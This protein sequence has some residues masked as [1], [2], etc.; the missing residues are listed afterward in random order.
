MSKPHAVLLVTDNLRVGGV[1]KVVLQIARLLSDADVRVGILAAGGP[2][3]SKLPAGVDF[4]R[5]SDK[6]DVLRRIRSTAVEFNYRIVHSHQRGVSSAARV[7]L[8]GTGIPIVEHVH[9]V[10]IPNFFARRFSFHGHRLIACGA[11]IAE[12]LH[13]DFQRT[14]SRVR[15]VLNAVP[16]LRKGERI[17][18]PA[19]KQDASQAPIRLITVA[20]MS[21]QKDPMR[22]LAVMEALNQKRPGGWHLTWV[23]GGDLEESFAAAI[24]DRNLP[25]DWLGERDDVPELLAESD[26]LLLTSQW[27][28]LPLV[29]LE[30]MRAGI[31][32]I[33]PDVGSCS[34]AIVDSQTG[35]LYPSEASSQDIAAR[36]ESVRSSLSDFGAAGRSRFMNQFTED[37][38]LEEIFSVYQELSK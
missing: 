28:G 33:A 38:M 21:K 16:S 36:L 4:H 35:V 7:V 8:V 1:Q 22:A 30:A 11:Q 2:L 19:Y 37:R 13:H 6:F 17:V 9:N 26:A 23:G 14:D 18:D 12:M 20:R 32:C 34:D 31:A 15:T 5:A 24:H 3:E 10:F 25:V 29:L 27:E